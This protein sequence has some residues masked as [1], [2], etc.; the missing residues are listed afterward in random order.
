MSAVFLP[1][2]P[3]TMGALH[4]A[5]REAAGYA[6]DEIVSQIEQLHDDIE[7]YRDDIRRLLEIIDTLAQ[8]VDELTEAQ[9]G[10]IA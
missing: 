8:R 3:I 2:D 7:G 5:L 6:R 9:E 10:A 1:S 4:D